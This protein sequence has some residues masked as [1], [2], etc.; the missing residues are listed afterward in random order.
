MKQGR[1]FGSHDIVVFAG[2]SH[3]SFITPPPPP[4]RVPS[5]TIIVDIAPQAASLHV[6]RST[7]MN[8]FMLLGKPGALI[9]LE[10]G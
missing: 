5:P 7:I 8:L 6:H 10:G 2:F 3:S 9:V 4:T 1:R